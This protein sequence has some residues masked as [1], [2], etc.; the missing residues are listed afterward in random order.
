MTNPIESTF[1]TIRLRHRRTMGCGNRIASLTQM[2]KSAQ[3]AAQGD[4]SS[5]APCCCPTCYKEPSS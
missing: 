3:S 2:F 5:T 4:G 1:A